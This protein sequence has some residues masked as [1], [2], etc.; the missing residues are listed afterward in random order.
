MSN[1]PMVNVWVALLACALAAF[2]GYAWGR[3]V[4]QQQTRAL[5]VRCQRALRMDE[6]EWEGDDE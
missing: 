6:D 4:S 1:P 5:C 3:D 2:I